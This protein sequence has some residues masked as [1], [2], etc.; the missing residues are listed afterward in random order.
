MKRIVDVLDKLNRAKRAPAIFVLCVAAAITLP[1]QTL[2]T[3]HSFDGLDGENPD[4]ALIQATDGNLYGT[5]Y[6]GGANGFIGGT[7]FKIAP[8]GAP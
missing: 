6:A 1:A 5:T 7:V 2:T 8:S 3:V 4:A